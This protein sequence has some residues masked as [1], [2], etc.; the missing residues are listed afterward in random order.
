M[1]EREGPLVKAFVELAD[2]LVA[3][4]D[5]IE[6]AQRLVDDCVRLLTVDAAGILLRAPEGG[7]Q[8]L[9]STSEQTRLLE[10]FQVQSEAGPCLQ[11]YGTGEVVVVDDLSE[12]VDRWPAFA[13]RAL[14]EGFHAVCAIPMRLRDERIGA[15][16][17]FS[18]A[19]GALSAPDLTVGQALADVA[20]IGILHQRMAT[21]TEVVN[22]QL[23]V[24]LNTRIIIE[25]AKGVLSERGG[26]NMDDAFKQ[27]RTYARSNNLRLSDFARDI[28]DGTA[29]AGVLID[30]PAR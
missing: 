12:Q 2:T 29:D 11:A 5:V 26:L 16:N 9:A 14:A 20:T 25:Q 3:D 10:L 27:L 15:I 23:Q 6:L 1:T 8:V 22:R 7:L 4:Y 18:T 13:R 17:V 19:T 28:V 30:R 24:A 21:R